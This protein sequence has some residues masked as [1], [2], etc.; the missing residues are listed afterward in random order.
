M[1]PFWKG[2]AFFYYFSWLPAQLGWPLLA[3]AGF[4]AW[5]FRRD[6]RQGMRLVL[7][8]ALSSYVFWALIPNRQMRFLMPGL[9]GLAVVAAA[10]CPQPLIWIAAAVSLFSASHAGP[11]DRPIREDWKIPE[12]LRAVEASA[13]GGP[14]LTAVSVIVNDER[15]NKL[16]M[17]WYADTL[18]YS[19]MQFRGVHDIPWELSAF[20]I[21]KTGRLGPAAVVAD[22][23][24]AQ[25]EM[26]TPGGWFARG[27]EERGRW[28]LP[29]GTDAVLYGRRRLAAPPFHARRFSP[30]PVSQA[31]RTPSAT[32]HW[33][34]S[35]SRTSEVQW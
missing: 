15:F 17:I 12:V 20:V 25:S 19:E 1:V 33:R 3:L 27:F 29:D 14:S 30:A 10:A 11:L 4:G 7:L 24:M 16:N 8:W 21:W 34:N 13:A 2:G 32:L 35:V 26:Q 18:G 6:R 5:R 9:S 23:S 22:F 28:P 31:R